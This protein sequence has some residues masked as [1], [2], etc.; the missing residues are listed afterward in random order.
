MEFLTADLAWLSPISP[1][2]ALS[3][4]GLLQGP[5]TQLMGASPWDGVWSKTRLGI[6]LPRGKDLLSLNLEGGRCL[7]NLTFQLLAAY[8][9]YNHIL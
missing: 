2:L 4:W 9:E 1:N 5:V 8:C 6:I 3:C 7:I